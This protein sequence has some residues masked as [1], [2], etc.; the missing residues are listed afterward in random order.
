MDAEDPADSGAV[1]VLK[2]PSLRK[3][4]RD[5]GENYGAL[6]RNFL[7]LNMWLTAFDQFLVVLPYLLVA[8]LLFYPEGQRVKMGVLVRLSDSFGKVFGSLSVVAEN[9]VGINEFCSAVFRL[10]QFEKSIRFPST[11]EHASAQLVPREVTRS[12]GR[13]K[14]A[15][16]AKTASSPPP[17]EAHIA[18]VELGESPP[19]KS[20]GEP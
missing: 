6:Y 9:W 14:A 8:P 15:F 18:Q 4:W 20:G 1:G 5:I 10:R 7:V 19:N 3:Q 11:V 2:R 16:P 13:G 12:D 17:A